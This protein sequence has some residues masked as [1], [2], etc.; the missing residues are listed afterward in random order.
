MKEFQDI[1][2]LKSQ[3]IEGETHNEN[4]KRYKSVENDRSQFININNVNVINVNGTPSDLNATPDAFL[5]GG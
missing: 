5:I 2:L 3:I 4:N 1:E